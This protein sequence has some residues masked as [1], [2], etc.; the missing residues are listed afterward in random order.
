[1]SAAREYVFDD[2]REDGWR[3]V[4][5]SPSIRDLDEEQRIPDI[6]KVPLSKFVTEDSV[7]HCNK[8]VL[9]EIALEDGIFYAANDNLNIDA[10][11]N[12]IAD[13]IDDFSCHLE[14]FFNYYTNKDDNEVMGN[15]ARLKEIYVNHFYR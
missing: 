6:I 3:S 2:L 9:I 7:L 15:A 8:P 10:E 12:S 5:P 14:Y 13:V 1:M 4:K 11:G